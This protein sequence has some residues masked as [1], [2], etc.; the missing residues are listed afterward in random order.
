MHV[1]IYVLH[2]VFLYRAHLSQMYVTLAD[3]ETLCLFQYIVLSMQP[4]I[5]K[6]WKKQ[7]Q[8][9]TFLGVNIHLKI[10]GAS[11]IAFNWNY[12]INAAINQ[13]RK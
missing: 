1:Y 4:G 9:Y 10:L 5:D 2:F 12:H 8:N 3:L 6:T 11:N 13:Q 7:V